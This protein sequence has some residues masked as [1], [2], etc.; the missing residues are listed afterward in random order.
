M[1][2]SFTHTPT[3]PEKTVL[4]R[5]WVKIDNGDISATPQY[6]RTDLTGVLKDKQ[7]L[8]DHLF[9]AKPL[10]NEN[11]KEMELFL[12]AVADNVCR[13][14]L[15]IIYQF[16]SWKYKQLFRH[17][18]AIKAQHRFETSPL[19]LNPFQ[20]IYQT[21]RTFSMYCPLCKKYN[22][23]DVAV[24][25]SE[26]VGSDEPQMFVNG[27]LQRFTRPCAMLYRNYSPLMVN[28]IYCFSD[29]HPTKVLV[30]NALVPPYK[31]MKYYVIHLL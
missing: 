29:S 18:R 30:D 21:Q 6:K 23:D 14:I 20:Y 31:T 15:K 2:K 11:P 3:T 1:D 17:A 13:D 22:I 9:T 25:N 16:Y 19:V 5:K 27:K 26:G 8:I 12:T 24:L 4:I 10:K 7:K 28:K